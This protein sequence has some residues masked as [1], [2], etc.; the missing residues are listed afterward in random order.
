MK[1]DTKYQI[2]FIIDIIDIG[3]WILSLFNSFHRFLS[4]RFLLFLA[5]FKLLAWLGSR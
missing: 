3:A 4:C 1:F 2:N 5:I